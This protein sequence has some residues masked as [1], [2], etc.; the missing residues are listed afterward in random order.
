[1]AGP[2]QARVKR[3]LGGVAARS[4]SSYNVVAITCFAQVVKVHDFKTN[5]LRAIKIIRNKKRFH[6]Q[7]LIELKV[8]QV[9][10]ERALV[11]TNHGAAPCAQLRRHQGLQRRWRR[12]ELAAWLC[13]PS[14][15]ATPR[16]ATTA[17]TW[18]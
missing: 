2:R 10:H 18:G 15:K 8:L 14:R 11:T 7:A 9:R 17:C 4:V 1:M 5:S 12:D 3:G 16:T 6:Q 13:R